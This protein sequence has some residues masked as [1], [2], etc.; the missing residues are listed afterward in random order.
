MKKKSSLLWI[1][2][3]IVLLALAAVIVFVYVPIYAREDVVVPSDAELYAYTE[4]KKE[5]TLE[6][7]DLLFILDPS[8]TQ[9]TV[10]NKETGYVWYSNPVGADSDKIAVASEKEK[11]QSVFLLTYTP[12]SGSPTVYNSLVHS[13]TNGVYSIEATDE[14][15]A[16]HYSVGK[17]SKTIYVP[18]AIT[19][20]RMDQ[21]TANMSKK[22]KNT[23]IGIYR[24]YDPAKLKES[25][26]EELL[27]LYPDL[28]NEPVYVMMPKQKDL[29]KTKAADMLAQF[30]YTRAEYEYDVSR[31][32]TDD[33]GANANVYNLTLH[34]R[35]SGNGLIVEV[36]FDE[37]KYPAAYP[38]TELTILPYL[39]AG[40]IND[41][42]YLIVPEGG[43]S[44]IRYNNGKSKQTA[45]SANVYGWDYAQARTN[46][47][48]E[49]RVAF[50]MFGGTGGSNDSFLCALEEGASYATIKAAISG[51]TSSYN[52]A[53]ASYTMIHR[54]QFQVSSKTTE[55]IFMPEESL[56]AGEKLVQRYLFLSTGDYA[57]MAA[58]YGDY[59]VESGQI[60][61]S[62]GTGEVPVVI[63]L[64]GA[65]DKMVKNMG[66][67]V[68]KP[69]SVTSF[70]QAEEIV[71][72]LNAAGLDHLRI[73]Y[74]GWANNG[75]KQQVFT[76]V[77]PVAAM[78][79][80]KALKQFVKAAQDDGNDVYLD[81]M[82]EFAYDSGLMEGLSVFSDAAQYT[83]RDRVIL[84]RFSPVYFAPIVA[85]DAYY[86]VNPD[87]MLRMARN[88]SDSVEEYGANGISYQ[89]M[90]YLLSADYTADRR[91]SREAALG[92]QLTAMEYAADRDQ[93]IMIRAGNLY[94]LGM[95]DT[96]THMNLKGTNY[97]ILDEQIPFLQI[98]LHGRVNYVGEPL[99]M[100]GDMETLLLNSA[101]YGAGL[102]F[103]FMY[104]D[105][106]VL[107]DT[108][109][110]AYVSTDWNR[111]KDVAVETLTKYRADME[112]L[113]S[114]RI[115][116]H[117]VISPDLSCTEYEDGTKVYVN[118]GTEDTVADGITIPARAYL[119]KGVYDE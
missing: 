117:S 4:D 92:M 23:A 40:G 72:E 28:N 14:E 32:S 10:T 116:G 16:I 82:S 69:V 52:N 68:R 113:F 102:A 64:L 20:A 11:M 36:P 89:D 37:I 38:I 47:I 45:Y 100:A 54:D 74:N 107:V 119:V 12:N 34:Y 84:R 109:Y 8:T 94:A 33:S 101:E 55:L 77:K 53:Y 24:L 7:E 66:V 41:E 2:R 73:R 56:P 96:V 85:E 6:N 95:A 49:T 19:Q 42:G 17:I 88:F 59:L 98:A 65:I 70:A 114:Q 81:G 58:A 44:I 76:S 97:T 30:G 103:T 50:P 57:D 104:E 18:D 118:Y 9:F 79:G 25:E 5:Y 99:N 26:K 63:D 67:P 15:I 29:A 105:A 3:G 31:Y 108:D 106:S 1:I 71:D 21:F 39:G 87:Y 27:S 43:G 83:T 80:E 51:R 48:S 78:G 112:G 111:W 61:A 86:L 115:T 60:P 93:K 22:E 46:L 62:S 13:V 91:V 90:G 35:L 110:T 75:I